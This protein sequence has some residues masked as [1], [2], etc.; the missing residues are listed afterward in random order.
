MKDGVSKN[1]VN[2]LAVF[3]KVGKKNAISTKIVAILKSIRGIYYQDRLSGRN[4]IIG[5]IYFC[6]SGVNRI[7]GHNTHVV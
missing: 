2:M 3:A 4:R 1:K 6:F 7:S 5:F